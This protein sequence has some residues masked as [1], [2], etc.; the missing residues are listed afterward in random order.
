VCT[1]RARAGGGG[2]A[3][4]TAHG[5]TLPS[6][7]PKHRPGDQSCGRALP[8]DPEACLPPASRSTLSKSPSPLVGSR[9]GATLQAQ[10]EGLGVRSCSPDRISPASGSTLS[11]SPESR[12]TSSLRKG[13][14][15]RGGGAGGTSVLRRSHPPVS[16]RARRQSSDGIQ[17]AT[18]RADSRTAGALNWFERMSAG[19]FNAQAFAQRRARRATLPWLGERA[20]TSHRSPSS[21][22]IT[23]GTPV[24]TRQ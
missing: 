22:N 1:R 18:A 19:L 5:S 11:R 4:G 15:S 7:L 8:N 6:T 14:C 2:G 24:S 10:R 21:V 12:E 3:H 9:M 16:L 23:V 13:H 20:S 17:D